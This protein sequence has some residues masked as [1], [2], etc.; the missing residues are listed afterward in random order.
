MKIGVP[1]E[2]KN[3]EYRVGLIPASVAEYVRHGHE[4]FVQKGAGLGSAI[5]DETYVEAGATMLDTADE[6]WQ[7]ASF[8]PCN[9]RWN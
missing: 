2:V 7:V 6:V 9:Q 8:L 3:H 5:L 4:V 1:T